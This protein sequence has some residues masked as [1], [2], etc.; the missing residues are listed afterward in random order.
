MTSLNYKK[1][2]PTN[3]YPCISTCIL[4]VL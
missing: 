2:F 1:S 3:G 4:L